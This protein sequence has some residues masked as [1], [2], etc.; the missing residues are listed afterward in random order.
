MSVLSDYT[1]EEQKLLMEGPRLGAVVVSAASLG[2]ERDT[3]SEGFAAAE[4]VLNSKGDYLDNTLIGSIQYELQQR[5]AHEE[6]FASFADLASAPGAKED[7]LAKLGQLSVLLAAK[8]NPAEAAGYKDWVMNTAAR[9]AQAG[10]EG[11]GFLGW[12]AVLVN[13]AEK[14]AIAEVATALGV[15]V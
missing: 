8:S 11:G 12:G 1:A 15:P 6:R 4:Y 3:A 7:A 14:A 5:S 13:D 9:T 10:E 2:K